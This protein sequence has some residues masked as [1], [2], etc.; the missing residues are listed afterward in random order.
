MKIEGKSVLGIVLGVSLLVAVAEGSRLGW[1]G[2]DPE[3]SDFTKQVKNKGEEH[4]IYLE[5]TDQNEQN[6]QEDEPDLDKEYILVSK[7]ITNEKIGNQVPLVKK[8]S[9]IFP[10]KK[11]TF[12][13]EGKNKRP[14]KINSYKNSLSDSLYVFDIS[15]T[16][17]GSGDVDPSPAPEGSGDIET[18]P[19]DVPEISTTIEGSGDIETPTTP[20][21]SEDTETT[22][23]DVP[24]ISTTIEGSG[25]IEA[26]TSPEGSEDTEATPT[27][28]PEISTTLE[29][30]GD[31]E[32]TYTSVTEVITT[33]S[34]VTEISTTLEGPGDIETPTTP[35][36]SEDTETTPTDVPEISTTIEGSGDIE[37]PTSPEGSEDT[38]T[39]P[40][41]IPEISTTL[42]ETG[43]TEAT[44]TSVTEVITT[45]STVTEISTTLEGPG[46][47]ETPTTPEGSEDTET[48]PTDIPEISTT[49][50]ETWD[51]E[52]TS[53]SV[54]EVITTT[55][56]VTEISTTLEGPGGIETPTS[57]EGSEDTETTPT[58]IPEISTTLEETWDTEVTSTSVTDISMT[59][60]SKETRSP[61][62]NIIYTTV[63]ITETSREDSGVTDTTVSG[64]METSP[65][66]ATQSS[67]ALFTTSD[68]SGKS[69][70]ADI[71]T[72][73]QTPGDLS[74]STP[75]IT[76]SKG[77]LMTTRGSEETL[78]AAGSSFTKPPSST[79][80]ESSK[81]KPSASAS[82]TT[83]F[84]TTESKTTT[85][86]P[87]TTKIT[88]KPNVPTIQQCHNGGTYDGI[89]CI[90]HENFYGPFC[91]NVI[92]RVVI[93]PSVTTTV[94]VRLRF[95]H[96][97]FDNNLKDDK[98]DEF[99]KFDTDFKKDMK[100]VYKD[101]PGYKDVKIL[102][103]RNGSVMVDYDVI[104]EIEFKSDINV[105]QQY[106]D[107]LKDVETG[108][109]SIVCK[110]SEDVKISNCISDEFQIT[111]TNDL[112][113]E[114]ELCLTNISAGFQDFY[115]PIVGETGLVC[116]SQCD[117]VSTKYTN[118][119]D[120]ICQIMN[121]TGPHCLCP[122][123][124][125]YIY[126]SPN[127][128]GKILKSGVYGGVGAAIGVLL[129]IICVAVAFFFTKNRDKT[130]DPFAS[131][132]EKDWYDDKEEDWNA[133]INN[134]VEYVN[135]VDQDFSKDSF[136]SREKFKPNLEAIDTT[137]EVKIQRP[138]VSHSLSDLQD[139]MGMESP[140]ASYLQ[141]SL[142]M[143]HITCQ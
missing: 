136:S 18:S 8:Y 92:D 111:E 141:H 46:D 143:D 119:Q 94:N 74:L 35:E 12:L 62:T 137:H 138:Q 51:T 69:S 59:P 11:K 103:I 25:D 130:W 28:I 5:S 91:E 123:T 118:C 26:P 33:L 38:E 73:F 86:I 128:N 13:N 67:Q 20:E 81:S 53:K 114:K 140:I 106:K 89:K 7:D 98:S 78:S 23:T 56:T 122:R 39:T 58:D 16:F 95:I 71:T 125:L 127:C 65:L 6:I 134:L 66:P 100:V 87:I 72:N 42:E 80:L 142:V 43:D 17:E 93:G 57:P 132:E 120:G 36:G 76:I 112:K 31:T 63:L 19:T 99:K 117:A 34:T 102:S 54:T 14:N 32:A 109:S 40:T 70:T 126:T 37:T 79:I 115:E 61:S 116:V 133:G 75:Y 85:R 29:E 104:I 107:V 96:L 50:V 77:S 121:N 24:E 4:K 9:I 27:D 90:C 49:L 1:L 22:T 10:S 48:S 52:A 30:T 68:V 3:K 113:S 60:V 105:T 15:K 44:Y 45:L 129:I 84:P 108:M 2:Q 97:E 88:A 82:L 110:S 135:N 83:I 101:V 21:G 124:D 64:D 55:S 131:D 41:D 47:I 139:S